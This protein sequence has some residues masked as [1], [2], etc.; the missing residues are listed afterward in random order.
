M[1]MMMFDLPLK[2]LCLDVYIQKSDDNNGNSGEAKAREAT[3][4]P[5]G[6]RQRLSK[7]LP[8]VVGTGRKV[9]DDG[10]RSILDDSKSILDDSKSIL[11]DGKSILY[12]G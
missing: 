2:I 10:G 8:G 11:D 1:I 5:K 7:N 4:E 3:I 12:F 9:L 6:G